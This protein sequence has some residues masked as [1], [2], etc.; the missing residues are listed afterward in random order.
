MAFGQGAHIAFNRFKVKL[1]LR[2]HLIAELCQ[3]FVI[4]IPIFNFSPSDSY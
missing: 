1:F 4:Y 2:I 3:H